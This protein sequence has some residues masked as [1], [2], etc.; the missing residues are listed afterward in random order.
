MSVVRPITK[1]GYTAWRYVQVRIS[2]L[3]SCLFTWYS[4]IVFLDTL[5][6]TLHK[7]IYYEDAMSACRRTNIFFY[8]GF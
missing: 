8:V 7:N 6:E 1:L 4:D 3:Y 5:D 2:L